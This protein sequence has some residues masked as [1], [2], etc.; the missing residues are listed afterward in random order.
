MRTFDPRPESPVDASHA[1]SLGKADRGTKS[2]CF[3]SE[4]IH[5]LGKILNLEPGE[6]G[7]VEEGQMCGFYSRRSSK[8]LLED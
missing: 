6:R 8:V 2:V 5:V 1:D 4:Q 3:R 7:L